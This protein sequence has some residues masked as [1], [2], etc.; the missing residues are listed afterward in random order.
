M[1][2]FG[3][4]IY[5]IFSWLLVFVVLIFIFSLSAQDA[6][7]SKELSDSFVS[8]T[9]QFLEVYIDGELLRKIAHML[10][11]TALSFTLYNGIFITWET[12]KTPIISLV[13]TVVCAIGDEIHQIFVPGRAF[14]F[15]DILIDSAGAV[16]GI[17]GYLILYKIYLFI[18]GRGNKNG[19][20]KTI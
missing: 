7:E 1:M 20:I 11:F 2:K 14:Q 6:E 15:S 9:L 8:K 16:I 18:K 5:L 4:T 19:S 17:I 13:L 3:K 10:E 12:K